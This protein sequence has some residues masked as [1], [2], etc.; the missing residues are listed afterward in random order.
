MHAIPDAAQLP[1]SLWSAMRDVHDVLRE[2]WGYSAFRPLQEQV[3]RQVLEGH[4]TL[5]LLPT[6]GGKSLCFQ[7]PALASGKLCLVISPLI[8]LINDQVAR[9]KERGVRAVA[10]TSGMDHHEIDNALETA[11]VGKAAFLYVSPERLGTELFKARLHRLPLGSIAVD[12]AHCI[13]QWGYD[14]RPA[15]M[16]VAELRDVHPQVPVIALTASATPEVAADIMEHLRFKRPNLIQGSFRRPEL[17]LWVSQ[18][19]DKM[20]RLLRIARNVPGSTIVYMRDRKGTVRTADM[21]RRHGFSAE[22]YHAGLPFEERDR[23]QRAWTKNEVRIVAA[24]NA[25]GMGIDKPDV[26]CVVHL[27]PP[28]DVESYYQEAGR[29][30]R[31]GAPAYAFLLVGEGDEAVLR[32]RMAAGFPTVP[33]VRRVFQAFAD[34][35][36]IAMGAGA[37]ETYPLDV[38]TLVQRTGV[39]AQKVMGCLKVLELDGTIAL[40]DGVRTPSRILMR[41]A[42]DTIYNIRVKDARLGPLLETLLR[43]YGGLYEEYAIVEEERMARHLGWSTS[44]VFASLHEL[45]RLNV[46]FY[47]PRNDKPALTLLVPRPDAARITPGA[48]ALCDRERRARIRMEAMADITFRPA[49]CRERAVLKYFGAE[50]P[51]DCGRCDACVRARATT[52]TYTPPGADPNMVSDVEQARWDVDNAAADH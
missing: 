27:A 48:E 8:A 43:M 46:V 45:Q 47:R 41:A 31:D 4:D 24:T 37:F 35:H 17:T 39:H 13:S 51:D 52:H 14:F 34:Q 5:A 19:E 33:E 30:G 16:R 36:R 49:G 1:V 11:A 2:T 20:G 23:I 15:Y 9:L 32:E 18:G 50:A 25:F 26:R 6:G 7:V 38:D 29:A 44:R 22:A 21:L 12:E 40:S 28:P 10:I 3:V 42:P